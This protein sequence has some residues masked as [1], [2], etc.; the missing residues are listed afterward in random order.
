MVKG[1]GLMVDPLGPLGSSSSQH[2]RTP[3]IVLWRDHDSFRITSSP[4]EED[5][6]G[7]HLYIY[8]YKYTHIYIYIYVMDT[9]PES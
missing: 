5:Q 7:R 2:R 9:Y 8:I 4:L 3:N 1:T 6:R